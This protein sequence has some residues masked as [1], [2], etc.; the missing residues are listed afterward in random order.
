MVASTEHVHLRPGGAVFNEHCTCLDPQSWPPAETLWSPDDGDDAADTVTVATAV[1][2]G[3]VVTLADPPARVPRVGPW[4]RR[5]VAAAHVLL[6][7]ARA[8]FT[9]RSRAWSARAWR[10]SKRAAVVARRVLVSLLLRLEALALVAGVAV[11]TW[12]A[13]EING[14]AGK[15]VLSAGLLFLGGAIGRVVQE[16]R[17]GSPR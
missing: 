15:M 3:P 8:A 16:V 11:A 13:W 17:S 7:R 10:A 12:A 2:S 4:V 9:K 5:R 6:R 1:M 14:T